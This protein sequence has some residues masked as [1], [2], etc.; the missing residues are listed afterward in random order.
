MTGWQKMEIV[1]GQSSIYES[2][3]RD[4]NPLPRAWDTP[5]TDYQSSC[6]FL[7]KKNFGKRA[8]DGT[9]TR[10]LQLGKLS[11]YQVSYFRF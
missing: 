3:R 9:R 10:C 1:N 11:L 6:N 7:L 8:E 5:E 4:S 2:G